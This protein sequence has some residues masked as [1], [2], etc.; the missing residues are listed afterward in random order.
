MIPFIEHVAAFTAAAAILTITP[1][2]DVA[3]VLRTAASEGPGRAMLAGL[4]IVAGLF[5]WGLIVAVGLGALL[6]ASE[7]AYNILRWAGAA[8]LLWLGA[9]LLLAPRDAVPLTG[10]ATEAE[11]SGARWFVRGFLTNILNPKV[12]VFYVSFVPQFIPA[13]ASVPAM[14]VLLTAIHA[15]L[16]T[17]WFA[18]L[19]L[20]TQPLG[21]LLR[22]GAVVAWLDRV[23]GGI[24]FAFAAR[25]ALSAQR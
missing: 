14:T 24:F 4:G 6:A 9:K 17:L 19:I 23:T 8:Y 2:L 10:A 5:G 13:G 1:G 3:L 20:A 18:M 15:V 16:T 7:L 21:R 11:G 25:L 22:K 12:G